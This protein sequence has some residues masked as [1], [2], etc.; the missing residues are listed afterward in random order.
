[1]NDEEK[2]EFEHFNLLAE[3]LTRAFVEGYNHP[4]AQELGSTLRKRSGT[5]LSCLDYSTITKVTRTTK[6]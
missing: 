2:R 4:D 3:K 1:M 6:Y 5:C